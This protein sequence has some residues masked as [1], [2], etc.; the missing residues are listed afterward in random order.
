MERLISLSTSPEADSTTASNKRSA[1]VMNAD[2][3]D[4]T[5]DLQ[6]STKRFIIFI[7]N[8]PRLY[9]KNKWSCAF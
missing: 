7:G 5:L 8:D 2:C 1:D 4:S 3:Y 6:S 9:K